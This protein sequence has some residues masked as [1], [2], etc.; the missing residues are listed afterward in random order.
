MSGDWSSDVCSSDLIDHLH[1]G[2]VAQYESSVD[3]ANGVYWTLQESEY[4][5]LSDEAARKVSNKYSERTVARK[6]IEIYNQATG[7]DA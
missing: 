4:Q 7:R 5:T 3:F 6:Y 2:Y 1:N